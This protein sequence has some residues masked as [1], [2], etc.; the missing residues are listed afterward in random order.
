MAAGGQDVQST[1]LV[2][3]FLETDGPQLTRLP[4]SHQGVERV[5]NGDTAAGKRRHAKWVLQSCPVAITVGDAPL[6][7]PVADEGFHC[8]V[9][10]NAQRRYLRI[11]EGDRAVGQPRH[12][13]RLGEVRGCR[14][15][16]TQALRSGS[17]DRDGGAACFGDGDDAMHPG[18]RDRDA[19]VVKP[20]A[21]PWRAQSGR[22]DGALATEEGD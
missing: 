2:H 4:D 11:G 6:E 13:A 18:F 8:A 7:E 14:R 16:V 3:G 5:R 15:T 19:T 1:G 12:P 20:E 21:V 22:E 17:R 9:A 10:Q